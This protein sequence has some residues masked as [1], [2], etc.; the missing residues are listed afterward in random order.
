MSGSSICPFHGATRPGTSTIAHRR[1][2]RQALRSASIRSGATA[3]GS[4][5]AVSMPRGITV[6]PLA[7]QVVALHHRL[8]RRSSTARSPG[9]RARAR[10]PRTRA[11]PETGGTSGSVVTSQ[12]AI[13]AAAM[14][15]LQAAADALGVHDV[16][17]LGRDQLLERARAAAELEWIDGGVGERNPFAAER[18]ELGRPAARRRRRSCARA[19]DCSSAWATLT[20]V[21]ATG[22]S[23]NA[24]TICRM[25]APARCAGN[26]RARRNRCSPTLSL[27][28]RR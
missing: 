13:C 28:Q 4:K 10:S 5:C 21:R 26:V 27:S 14:L 20:A 22:S 3:A 2:I 9:R 6:M 18:F 15:A 1:R 23:R 17:A 11:D 16:D 19:P 25:V 24:G 7:R 12:T 8:R